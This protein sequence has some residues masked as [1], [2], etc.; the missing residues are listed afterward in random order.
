MRRR[1]DAPVRTRIKA[2]FQ[3]G[4]AAAKLLKRASSRACEACFLPDLVEAAR[5]AGVAALQV[6]GPNLEPAGDPDVDRVV[7]GQRA[8]GDRGRRGCEE[9]GSGHDD[10]LTGAVRLP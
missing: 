2:R 5:I 9:H 3:P 6:E 7:L 4:K 8:A 1:G 10:S